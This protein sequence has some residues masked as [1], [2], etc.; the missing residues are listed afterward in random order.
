MDPTAPASKFKTPYVNAKFI[1][2][3]MFLLIL[4]L[5]FVTKDGKSWLTYYTTFESFTAFF[6][7]LPVYSFF[8]GFAIFA[9]LAFRYSFSLIPSLGLLCCFYMLS[10]LGYKNW[11]YFMIWLVIGLIIYFIY[12]RRHSK[13]AKKD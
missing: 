5:L 12:G 13:L 8:V 2:P 7:K 9:V 3:G 4:I 11:L 6:T 1:V 10:Q